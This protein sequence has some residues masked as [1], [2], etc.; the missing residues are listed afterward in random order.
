MRIFAGINCKLFHSLFPWIPAHASYARLKTLENRLK[1]AVSV[2]K[3]VDEFPSNCRFAFLPS[4]LLSFA[5]NCLLLKICYGK[6]FIEQRTRKVS[7]EIFLFA[8]CHCAIKISIWGI[9][10]TNDVSTN[11][12][13]K[14]IFLLKGNINF[15]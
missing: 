10:T 7:K 2:L 6:S 4:F 8:V 13:S 12:R 9:E 14:S 1:H 11:K 5:R 3:I 15:T